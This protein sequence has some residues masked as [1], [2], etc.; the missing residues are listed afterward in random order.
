MSIP[1]RPLISLGDIR[2]LLSLGQK[3]SQLGELPNTKEKCA[4][5]K[6]GKMCCLSAIELAF[7]DAK[8]PINKFV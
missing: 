2:E 1:L 5:E 4:G 6:K 7:I 8:L 3:R